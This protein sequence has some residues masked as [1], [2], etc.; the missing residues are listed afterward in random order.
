MG[1]RFIGE[2]ITRWIT[3]REDNDLMIL[4]EDFSYQRK[5][6]KIYTA[7]QGMIFDGATIPRWVWTLVGSPYTGP[8]RKPAIIHDQICLD[9]HAG[10]APCDSA[11]AAA[12]FREGI[13]DE[14][15]SWLLAWIMWFSVKTFGPKF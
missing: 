10:I 1:G 14:G 8:Q 15:G 3:D 11:T 12:I 6:G 2:A 4:M 13:R 7:R 5:D 9:G